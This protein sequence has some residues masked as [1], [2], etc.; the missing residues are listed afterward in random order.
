[1]IESSEA[2]RAAQQATQGNSPETSSL[3]GGEAPASGGKPSA[4]ASGPTENWEQ[5][6]ASLE[7]Q[8]KEKDSKYVYLYAEFENFKKRAQKE[9]SDLLKFGWESVA[10]ELLQT[11]DN[12]EL[13]I[14]H[15]PPTADSTWSS[16]IR[17]VF[18]QF[19]SALQKNGVQGI[20]CQGKEFDPN[21][22]EAVGQEPSP[23]PGG[24]VLKEL[25]KGYTLHGRLLRPSRVI[26]SL[27][28]QSGA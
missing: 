1:M 11:A 19:Q 28:P 25:S 18:E 9:R 16:G 26:L 24:T 20:D 7:S 13:A 22:H 2:N 27:G 12:L 10:K 4:A 5:K 3:Q 23:Q 21:L 8:I 17:L 6:L 14:S 15:L